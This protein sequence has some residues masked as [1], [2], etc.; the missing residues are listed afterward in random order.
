VTDGA[1]GL[2]ATTSDP[3]G[4]TDGPPPD[5]IGFH[6]GEPVATP[7]RVQFH[8]EVDDVDAVVE[9]LTAQGV[10]FDEPPADRPWGVRSASCTDPAGHSVE[11]T[12]PFPRPDA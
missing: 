1:A 3:C 2:P 5:H 9:R 10:V 8:A 4:V 7:E 11:F 12:T 6:V